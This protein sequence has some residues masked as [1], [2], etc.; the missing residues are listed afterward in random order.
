MIS[1]IAD[2]I[3]QDTNSVL[4]S[5]RNANRS[6]SNKFGV[7]NQVGPPKFNMIQSKHVN[8][9][10]PPCFST[11]NKKFGNLESIRNDES[12]NV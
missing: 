12:A 10:M 4:P 6:Q 1:A 5:N 7:V 3:F 9:V 11:R 2:Q 8:D